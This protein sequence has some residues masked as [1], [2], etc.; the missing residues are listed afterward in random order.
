MPEE[1]NRIN[2]TITINMAQS[3]INYIE[4]NILEVLT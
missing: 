2:N 3:I 1:S 4:D